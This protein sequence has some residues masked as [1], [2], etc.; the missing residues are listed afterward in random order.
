MNKWIKIGGVVSAAALVGVI[1][2]SAATFAQT[3]V[4]TGTAAVVQNGLGFGGPGGLDLFGPRGFGGNIDGEALLAKALNI[5][6]KDLRAAEQKAETDAVNQAVAN[7][8]MTQKQADL[9]LAR[10]KLAGYIDQDAL[11]AKVLGISVDQLQQARAKGT[12][13]QALIASLNLDAT[14]VRTDLQTAYQNAV[15]QAVTDGVITQA[16]ADQVL[17]GPAA[18]SGLRGDFGGRGGPHGFGGPGRGNGQPNGPA[19]ASTP[20]GTGA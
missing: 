2:I 11:T 10:I 20:A 14:K 9:A 13:M 5:T 3:Q 8:D 15:K 18:G 4:S 19:P 7:G 1:A 17:S 16:Q 12:S 6:V